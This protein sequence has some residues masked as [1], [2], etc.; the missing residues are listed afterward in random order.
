MALMVRECKI[1]SE[2]RFRPGLEVGYCFLRKAEGLWRGV[3]RKGKER[4]G[5]ERELDLNRIWN[6]G[7]RI[8]D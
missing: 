4:K 7:S 8:G 6:D 3:E 1:G 2:V 5:K